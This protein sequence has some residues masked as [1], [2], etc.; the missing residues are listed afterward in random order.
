MPDLIIRCINSKDIVGNLIDFFSAGYLDHI[1]FGEPDGR[2]TGAR[3]E[4]GVQTRAANYCKPALELVYA[5]SVP[6]WQY[7]AIMNF[8]HAQIG[9]PY[10]FSDIGGILFHNNWHNVD[11]WICSELVTAGCDIGQFYLL[12]VLPGF[13]HRITPK[14]VHLSP[15]LRGHLVKR[16]PELKVA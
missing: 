3:A 11:K 6:Q 8:V 12:N 15:K 2:W 14:E 10:D 1:E 7:D 4:G 5:I 9:K 16:Y 13:T